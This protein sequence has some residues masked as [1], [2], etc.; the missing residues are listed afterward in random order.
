MH[1]LFFYA[2]IIKYVVFVSIIASVARV[3]FDFLSLVYKK[4]SLSLIYMW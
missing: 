1:G 3:K 4:Y 2:A